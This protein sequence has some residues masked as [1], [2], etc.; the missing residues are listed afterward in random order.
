VVQPAEVTDDR[1]QRGGHDGLV[2]RG[3]QDRQH[4]RAVHHDEPAPGSDG[5][6]GLASGRLASDGL[7]DR[8]VRHA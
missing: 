4:E 1:G 7:A 6:G 3:Q 5:G 2:Q 8:T